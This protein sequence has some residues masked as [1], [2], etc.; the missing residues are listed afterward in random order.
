MSPI[1]EVSPHYIQTHRAE[2]PRP[3]VTSLMTWENVELGPGT[4]YRVLSAKTGKV[5][6]KKIQLP[7][8]NPTWVP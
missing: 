8:A 7:K 3:E 4:D 5:R 6:E 1:R 2:L